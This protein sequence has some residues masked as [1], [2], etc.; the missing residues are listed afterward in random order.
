[1]RGGWAFGAF[2]ILAT[3]AAAQDLGLRGSP[4]LAPTS[5]QATN[6]ALTDVV[7]APFAPTRT[8][9]TM[10]ASSGRYGVEFTPQAESNAYGGTNTAAELRVT[11]ELGKRRDGDQGR[12]FL[13]ASAG[14]RSIEIPENAQRWTGGERNSLVSDAKAG[15]GWRDKRM[16]TSLGYVRRKAPQ[17]YNGNGM[18][19]RGG[20]MVGFSLTFRPGA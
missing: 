3:P 11:R 5:V 8:A 6:Q 12:Y 10:S 1:M 14:R 7:F 9:S 18:E 17:S 20:G 19:K 16:E 4:D 2:F 15:V 13:Y